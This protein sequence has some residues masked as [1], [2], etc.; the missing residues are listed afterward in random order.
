M[1]TKPFMNIIVA[2][3]EINTIGHEGKIPWAPIP[4]DFNWY[5][6]H[7]T[8]TKDPS[9]RV[10]LIIGRVSFDE[11]IKFDQNY[12]SRWHF[13]V[14]T[15]QSS[16]DFYDTHRNIDQINRVNIVNS[17]DE[18]AQKAKELLDTPEAMIESVYVF[19]GV[20]I[21]EDAIKSK[22]VKRIYITRVFAKL[23]ECNRRLSNFPLYDFKRIKRSQ[24][25]LLSE[26][27]DQIIEENGWKYQFQIYERND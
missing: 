17:F 4:T 9:K 5:I 23:P 21:Y 26:L 12:V 18:A 20:Q 14:V 22:L 6:T 1:D 25:E 3:D 2:M 16:Q 13:I 11:T 8:T 24:H 19:G 10:A 27:D 7:A 15:R